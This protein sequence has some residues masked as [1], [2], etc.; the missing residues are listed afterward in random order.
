MGRDKEYRGDG[1]SLRIEQGFREIVFLIISRGGSA[2]KL[3]GEWIGKN[4][5][6]IGIVLAQDT[7][8]AEVPGIV[9]DVETGLGA[10]H[11]GYRI[12]RVLAVDTVPEVEQQAALSELEDMGFEVERS[13]DLRQISTTWKPGAKRPD[14]SK[15]AK[16]FALRM[17]KL[18]GAL[19]GSRPRIEVLAR[20]KEFATD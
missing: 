20:S 9:R 1:F 14:S 18:I 12:S 17:Q 7:D 10:L 13:A 4:W 19:S 16:E 11:I 15:A 3:E 2:R 8:P 6:G 5:N